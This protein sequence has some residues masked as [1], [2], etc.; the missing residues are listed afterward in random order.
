MRAK[1]IR[2]LDPKAAMGTGM[3]S[4][5]PEWNLF[6]LLHQEANDSENFQGV[7][8]IDYEHCMPYQHPNTTVSVMECEPR[9][10]IESKFKYS[11]DTNGK[12]IKF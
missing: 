1:F 4:Q 7:T 12:N 2:G 11:T 5:F 6:H 3:A 9:F 10:S 8:P